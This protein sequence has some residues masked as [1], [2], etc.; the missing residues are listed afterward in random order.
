M[1]GLGPAQGTLGPFALGAAGDLRRSIAEGGFRAIDLQTVERSV[2]WP[3]AQV[4]VRVTAAAAPSNLA[5]LATRR[6]AALAV[7]AAEVA[8]EMLPV[9]TPAGAL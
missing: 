9:R 2:R 5:A 1:R 7:S 8:A 4:L 6:E 3:S